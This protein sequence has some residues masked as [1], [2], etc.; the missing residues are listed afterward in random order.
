MHARSADPACF[1]RHCIDVR[2]RW[3]LIRDSPALT[4][5]PHVPSSIADHG[6]ER[7]PA[8]RRALHG[9][10]HASIWA[11]PRIPNVLIRG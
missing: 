11:S 8:M 6:D 9:S 2:S 4:P 5:E 7:I 10:R 1:S 3:R